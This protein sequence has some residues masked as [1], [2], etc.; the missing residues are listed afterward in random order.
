MK[1][2]NT[3]GTLSI[4]EKEDYEERHIVLD[5]DLFDLRMSELNDYLLE[6]YDDYTEGCSHPV[7]F[8]IT[9]PGTEEDIED[10]YE[11]YIISLLEKIV[12][13]KTSKKERRWAAREEI[14][15]ALNLNQMNINSLLNYNCK[16]EEFNIVIQDTKGQAYYQMLE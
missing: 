15:S 4:V 2:L 16:C 7:L 1:F 14:K 5:D 11:M 8:K 6:E 12:D 9:A 13:I 3:K 10:M